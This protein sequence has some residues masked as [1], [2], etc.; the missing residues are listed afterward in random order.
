MEAGKQTDMPEFESVEDWLIFLKMD[1]HLELFQAANVDSLE[2]VKKLEDK[3]LREMG[4]KLIGHRNKMNKSIKSM[5]GR[6]VNRGMDGD[7]AAI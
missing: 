5:K 2:R 6:F 3:D 7:E 4:V 1:S